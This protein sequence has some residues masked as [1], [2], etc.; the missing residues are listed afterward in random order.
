MNISWHYPQIIFI[1]VACW[2]VD[3]TVQVEEHLITFCIGHTIKLE[4]IV[5]WMYLTVTSEQHDPHEHLTHE[6]TLTSPQIRV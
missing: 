6:T 3:D 4:Q 2:N 1:D 5:S